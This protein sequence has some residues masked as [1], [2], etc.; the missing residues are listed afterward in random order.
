MTM[1]S[2]LIKYQTLR[3]DDMANTRQNEWQ[4]KEMTVVANND[5]M[6]AIEV[7]RNINIDR[8]FRLKEVEI[9]GQVDVII[10]KLR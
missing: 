4:D 9:S 5:A 6:D 10:E 7:V 8:E 3:K 1:T 2:Y